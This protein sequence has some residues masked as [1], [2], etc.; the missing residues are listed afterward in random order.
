MVRQL[1][2]TS[3]FLLLN[4]FEL[5][6]FMA[7]HADQFDVNTRLSVQQDLLLYLIL[8]LRGKCQAKTVFLNFLPSC[9]CHAQVSEYFP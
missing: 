4:K 7:F 6:V 5:W 8:S 1:I 9:F 2:L 3:N